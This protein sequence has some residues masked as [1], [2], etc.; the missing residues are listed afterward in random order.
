[1]KKSDPMHAVFKDKT[2]FDVQNPIVGSLIAQVQENR[3]REREGEL[4]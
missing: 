4:I 1:M 2:K 3:A